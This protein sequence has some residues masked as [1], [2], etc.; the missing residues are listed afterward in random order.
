MQGDPETSGPL[1]Q[2][3]DLVFIAFVYCLKAEMSLMCRQKFHGKEGC[4]LD[5]LSAFGTSGGLFIL[6]SPLSMVSLTAVRDK[7]NKAFPWLL[8]ADRGQ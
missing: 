5:H 7:E 3:G 8:P 4:L 1:G 6:Q 2:V